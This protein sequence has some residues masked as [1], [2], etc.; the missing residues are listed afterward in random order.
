MHPFKFGP[1]QYVSGTVPRFKP[2]D[3][4]M[5]ATPFIIGDETIL[6][7]SRNRF[8]TIGAYAPWPS[9]EKG[10]GGSNE[11]FHL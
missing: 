3:R 4:W 1:I 5:T 8:E 7:L 2:I 10:A 6:P 9:A 11:P